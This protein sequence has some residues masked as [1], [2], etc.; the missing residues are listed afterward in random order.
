M[1][2]QLAADDRRIA[3]VGMAFRFPGADC[4]PDFWQNLRNRV[5][6]VRRFSTAELAAAGVAEE[7]YRSPDFVGAS[8]LLP[9]IGDF[10]ASFFGMS[11]NTAKVTDP[12]H[13][14]FLEFVTSPNSDRASPVSVLRAPQLQSPGQMLAH[15]VG[16]ERG[17]VSEEQGAEA[18][19]DVDIAVAVDVLDPG[20]LPRRPAI[21]YSISF[22]RLRKPT[23][24]RLSASVG[25]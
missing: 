15:V 9:G 10:D 8:G 1:T 18:H 20:S 13:R 23:A 24:A 5:S 16:H 19:G 11:P 7:E 12:Q 4:E 14:L 6:H 25:R 22:V 2:Q 21:G 3:I 17:V